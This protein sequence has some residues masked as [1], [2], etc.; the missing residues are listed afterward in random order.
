MKDC[1]GF[2]F[3]SKYLKFLIFENL[4]IGFLITLFGR[5]KLH[6]NAHDFVKEMCVPVEFGVEKWH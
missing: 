1:L 4:K 2:F 3:K 5:F 6:P